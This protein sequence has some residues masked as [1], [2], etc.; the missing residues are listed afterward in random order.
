MRQWKDDSI[1]GRD[2]RLSV[3]TI[4]ATRALLRDRKCNRH[5]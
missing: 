3:S 5:I 4:N 2:S 1:G